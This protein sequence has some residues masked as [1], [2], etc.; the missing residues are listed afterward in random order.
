MIEG[1]ESCSADLETTGNLFTISLVGK[2]NSVAEFFEN[3]KGTGNSI[4]REKSKYFSSTKSILKPIHTLD[5]L[6]A[7]HPPVQLLK[8]DIQGA[9]LDAL[10]G[11]ERVLESVEVVILE[12]SLINYNEGAPL[13]L[14]TLSY[15]NERGFD[16]FDLQD[17]TT[18]SNQGQSYLAQVDFVLVRRNSPLFTRK[19]KMIEGT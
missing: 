19:T 5:T 7:G 11:A 12:I 1:S 14:D 18:L 8:L 3:K 15:L 13:A 10:K 2:L 9:E 6:M 17:F 16:L 4:Y